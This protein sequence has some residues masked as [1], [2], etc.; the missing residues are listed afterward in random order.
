MLII[1]IGFGLYPQFAEFLHW[2]IPIF[3]WHV[4]EV[5]RDEILYP[6]WVNVSL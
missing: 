5:F 4:V 1:N 2:E 3:E 6:L